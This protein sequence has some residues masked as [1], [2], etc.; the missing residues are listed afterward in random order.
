MRHTP[1]PAAAGDEMTAGALLAGAAR[2]WDRFWFTPADPTTLGFMRICAGLLVFYVHLTYSWGLLSYIGPEAW[3]DHDVATYMIRDIEQQ[4][5]TLG[6]D[7]RWETHDR[8]NYFWSPFFHVTS[9]KYIIALHVFFLAAMLL[10]AAGVA[11]R[12]TAAISW[13][14]A[15]SYVQRASSTVFGLDTMMMITLLYLMIGPSGAALSVDRLWQVWRA[16]KRGEAPPPLEPSVLANF[17]I[18]LFQV[19]FC[20]IYL[21][22]GTS[23]LLGSTWWSGTALNLVLLN[24]SF[25]P[26]DWAPYYR[27]MKFLATSR[28]M[29]ELFVTGGIIFTLVIEIG[30]PFLVWDR[31][32]R[33]LMICG[34]VLLHTGIA[35]CMGLTTFSL[36][37]II[38]VSSFVPPEVVR[39]QVERIKEAWRER[40][41]ARAAARE[42]REL[43]A[44][45]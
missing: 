22:G 5:P 39:A 11:T 26:M 37:M 30:F 21:A 1:P 34:S 3:L 8:G 24:A 36:M 29:W 25:A 33:W 12:W 7:V 2:G 14:A 32:W 31:R 44:A 42:A 15:V 38:M 18:R 16:K 9:A 17:T 41:A 13:L 6:W 10:L 19:H 23:K 43:V 20:I 40:Q 35:I 28:W 45:R 4:R 27:L